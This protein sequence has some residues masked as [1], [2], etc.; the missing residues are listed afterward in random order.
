MISRGKER[1]DGRQATLRS[2]LDDFE[3]SGRDDAVSI[4]DV[5]ETFEH[6]SLGVL[7]TLFG[8]MAALPIIG[9]IPGM[10]IVLGTLILIV[11]GEWV[12]GR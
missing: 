12:V 9:D 7:L 11:V 10:S 6:R 1:N 2:V 5:L 8:L 4:G 3:H